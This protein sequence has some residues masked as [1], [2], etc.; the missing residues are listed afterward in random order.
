MDEINSTGVDIN[1]HIKEH[2]V[3]NISVESVIEGVQR[4]KLGKWDGEEDLNYDHI[5]H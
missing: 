5:V 2:G 4:L 3:Y 1:K